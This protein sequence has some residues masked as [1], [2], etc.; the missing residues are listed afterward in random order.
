MDIC[1]ASDDNYAIHM[2]VCI[3]SIAKNNSSNITIHILNNNISQMNLNKLKQIET[4]FQNIKIHFYNVNKYFNENNIDDLIKHQLS[5]NDF[6]KLLG[7]SAFSRLFLENIIPPNIE[8]ILYLDAD[9]IVL[10]DLDELFKINIEDYYIAGVVDVMA[11]ITK[12]FYEEKNKV[13]VMVNSGVLLINLSKW[14]KINFSKLAI[15]LIK[16]YE[17]KNYL[18]DQNIINIICREQILLLNPKFNVMSE[19]FYVNYK[20]NLKIN[21]YF[22]S[23]DKFY[24]PELIN[25]S[26]KNPTIIHF[27]SQIWDRP[28]IREIG[29]IKHK[30]KNP[31]NSCYDYYKKLSPWSNAKLQQN[32]KQFKEKVYYESIRFIMIYFPAILLAFMHFVKNK[33]KK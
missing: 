11:N 12:Y 4:Q 22:G 25:E 13:D 31:F 9:T 1:M 21:N 7:I 30:T 15:N 17:D 28:W 32:N 18:H 29:L 24:T 33:I 16:E 19:Y 20:K 26:L 5:N 2:G 10:N 23:T 14:R 3:V 27:I 8:K 6:Y